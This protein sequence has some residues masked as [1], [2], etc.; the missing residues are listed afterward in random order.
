MINTRK[1]RGFTLVEILVATAILSVLVG[2]F[3][4][5]ISQSNALGQLARADADRIDKVGIV[6]DMMRRDL[7]GALLP[8]VPTTQNSL[9]FVLNPS[10]AKGITADLQNPH[11]V[12]W[13]APVAS[14]LSNGDIATVGYF[15]RRDTTSTPPRSTLCRLQVD[16]S[17]P[18]YLVESSAA[19]LDKTL[20]LDAK[21]SAVAPNYP[22][23]LIEGALALWIRA[24]DDKDQPFYQWSSRTPPLQGGSKAHLPKA[25]EVVLVIVDQKTIDAVITLPTPTTGNDASLMDDDV[26]SFLSNLPPPIKKGARVFRSVIPITNYRVTP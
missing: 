16:S 4:Q 14:E 12:F 2:F 25:L 21:A 6:F 10:T 22:G 20:V 9:E 5:A 8:V 13:Q 18:A 19:W 15:I 11:S 3:F 24:I 7:A 1:E 23:L 26:D 17:D